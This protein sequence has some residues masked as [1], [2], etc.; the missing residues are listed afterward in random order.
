MKV[1]FFPL[2][3]FH[4]SMSKLLIVRIKMLPECALALAKVQRCILTFVHV[5]ILSTYLDKK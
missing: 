5:A 2:L 4:V 1:I 3:H